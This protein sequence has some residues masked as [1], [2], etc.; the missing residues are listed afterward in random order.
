MAWSRNGDYLCFTRPNDFG[1][2]LHIW[3][4]KG[5]ESHFSFPFHLFFVPLRVSPF[6]FR[7]VLIP[8]MTFLYCALFSPDLSGESGG[9]TQDQDAPL[10]APVTALAWAEPSSGAPG[11]NHAAEVPVEGAAAAAASNSIAEDLS[12]AGASS[13]SALLFCEPVLLVGRADGVVAVRENSWCGAVEA[14]EELC[15]EG[16]EWNVK[17]VYF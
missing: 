15:R 17:S 7:P 13:S 5:G 14:V 11:E 4:F 1:C 9:G 16:G 3:S 8:E 10:P 6:L 12:A 2:S